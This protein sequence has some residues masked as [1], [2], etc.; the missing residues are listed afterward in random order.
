MRMLLQLTLV[1]VTVCIGQAQSIA[2][3]ENLDLAPDSWLNGSNGELG[4]SSGDAYLSVANNSG[5]WSGWSISN[6]TDTTTP[7][8]TNQYSAITGSGYQSETYAVAYQ[9]EPVTMLI[10]ES[11]VGDSI[12]GLYI[13]NSTYAYLSIRDGDSFAKKFGGVS[14]DDPD[15]FYVSVQGFIDGEQSGEELQF[16]LADYQFEDNSMDYIVDEWTWWDL[17]SMGVVDSLSFSLFSSDTGDFGIQTPAYFC[18]D[19]VTTGNISTSTSEAV[20][21]RPVIHPNPAS[22]EI[23]LPSEMVYHIANIS[24][25]S[26]LSGKSRRVDIQSLASGTYTITLIDELGHRSSQIFYKR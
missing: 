18:V 8:F 5:Y 10:G 11:S 23:Q 25:Q 13:T 6:T 16:Y 20:V 2:D 15:F 1:F 14:G 4:Y 12:Q 3:F 22:I 19:D 21:P 7:G 17:S 24:G 9:F 26:L